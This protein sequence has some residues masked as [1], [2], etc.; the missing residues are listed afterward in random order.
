MSIESYIVLTSGATLPSR[1]NFQFELLDA[2]V[3]SQNTLGNKQI[4][5]STAGIVATNLLNL[6][7]DEATVILNEDSEALVAI[8]SNSTNQ[9]TQ[10][11]QVYQNDYATVQTGES[12]ANTAVQSEQTNVSQD[13]TNISNLVSLAQTLI[14]IGQY[15]AGLVQSA[16]TT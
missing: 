11:N 2:T 15:V 12:N 1:P 13:S 5:D 9:I 4:S 7:Y 10:Q 3:N 6:E 8:N 16:Y 14:T